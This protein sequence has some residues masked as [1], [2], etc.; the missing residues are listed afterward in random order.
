MLEWSFSTKPYDIAFSVLL[1]SAVKR[2]Y[3][4]LPAHKVTQGGCLPVTESG[5][6]VLVW[7]NR[8][9]WL[10]GKQ[11]FFTVR[12]IDASAVAE[13]ASESTHR[14]LQQAAQ[15]EGEEGAAARAIAASAN[16]VLDP[17][18]RSGAAPQKRYCATQ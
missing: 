14:A 13:H 12:C 5:T 3:R 15:E 7:S 1:N 16:A 9:S 11:L 2:R 8:Y 6:C 10:T 18:Q 17:D 4:R